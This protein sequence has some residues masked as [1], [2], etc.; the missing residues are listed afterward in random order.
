MSDRVKNSRR[1]RIAQYVGD[2]GESYAEGQF[3]MAL[4]LGILAHYEHNEPRTNFING[5]LMHEKPSVSDYTGMLEGGRVL[6]EEVKSRAAKRLYKSE[7]EPKQQA[8]LE[9]TARGGGLA[10]L[11]VEF[12]SA[13]APFFRRFA[14]PWLEVP[15][16]VV[17]S[18]ESIS[19]EQP[20]LAQWLIQPDTCHLLRWHAGGPRS[21][22]WSPQPK[23][24]Y[25]RE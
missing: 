4:R 21:W 18:A 14:I 7:V 22:N 15:W 11:L 17:K 13:S 2:A 6:A 24:V 19:V 5:Q 8:H 20:E 16:Q 3:M 9:A 10:I 25:P 12:R 1:G 23:R